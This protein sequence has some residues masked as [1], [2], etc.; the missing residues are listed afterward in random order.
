MICLHWTLQ[1]Q[2]SLSK[3]SWNKT[4]AEVRSQKPYFHTAVYLP[5]EWE[6]K[7][8]WVKL[9][10]NWVTCSAWVSSLLRQKRFEHFSRR[11]MEQCKKK[12]VW[13]H[14]QSTWKK[15]YYIAC[16]FFLTGDLTVYSELILIITIRFLFYV[17]LKKLLFVEKNGCM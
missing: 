6:S 5:K 13:N 12:H 7:T 2:L 14:K 9:P 8:T 1:F 11:L 17:I 3:K 10:I 15:N 16:F 4:K